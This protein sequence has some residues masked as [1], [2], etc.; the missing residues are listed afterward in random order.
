MFCYRCGQR[1]AD[2]VRIC[3][4]CGAV[5]IYDKDGKMREEP[6]KKPEADPFYSYSYDTRST[7]PAG[8]GGNTGNTASDSYTYGNYGTGSYNGSY[9]ANPQYSTVYTPMTSPN[10]K[11]DGFAAAGLVAGIIGACACCFP[12]VGVP[13]CLIGIIFSILG[14]KSQTRKNMAI[15]ALVISG[16]FLILN[17]VM[18]AAVIYSANH[19]DEFAQIYSDQFGI[20]IFEYLR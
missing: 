9:N 4:T 8:D 6:E 3:P 1:L 2:T 15:V 16:V 20:D 13:V 17:G 12:Y 14:L 11:A 7:D 19:L 18:L 10:P 5:I